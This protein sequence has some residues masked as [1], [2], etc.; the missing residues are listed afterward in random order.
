MNGAALQAFLHA[1]S[2][3]DV[4]TLDRYL[5]ANLDWLEA[6]GGLHWE[7]AGAHVDPGVSFARA[8]IGDGARV[9]GSGELAR[10]VV[11][12]GATVSAPVRDAIVTRSGTVPVDR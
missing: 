1:G 10:C 7:G 6:R 11:W 9:L 3:F 8:L 4:G 2:F 12:P 5:E